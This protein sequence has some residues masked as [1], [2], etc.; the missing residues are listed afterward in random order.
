[1]K[2]QVWL[3]SGFCLFLATNAAGDLVKPNEPQP[4]SAPQP[5]RKSPMESLK[6]IRKTKDY[7]DL[8]TLPGVKIDL[9]YATKDNFMGINMYGKF[10]TA[11][12]H[13]EAAEKFKKAVQNLKKEKPGWSFIVFDSLRPRSVQW[14]MWEKVK[15][16]KDRK[17]VANAEKGSVHNYGF[18][19]DLSLLDKKG[20]LVDMGTPYDTFSDLAEPQLEEKFLKEGKLTQKQVDHR[21]I[22][23]KVMTEAGFIQ[24][25]HEW[26]HYDAKTREELQKNYRI[27]E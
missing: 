11:F 22:L 25:S 26:W 27:I 14:I 10:K 13:K 24:L 1:M 20:R 6:E 3:I 18:A 17:Y 21:L 16:T 2:R 8:S 23:R 5:Q 19:L 12:L 15:D 9:K 4:V 7:V